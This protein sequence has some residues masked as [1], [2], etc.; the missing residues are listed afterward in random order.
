MIIPPPLVLAVTIA[1]LYGFL[2]YLLFGKGWLRLPIYWLVGIGGFAIGQ[3]LTNLIGFSLVS[4]GSVS[5]L[6][7][8]LVSWFSL[9]AVYAL[10][11]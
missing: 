10:V 6:E 11:R 2:F 9:F 5:L 8:S 1:S 3:L 4:I 7:G